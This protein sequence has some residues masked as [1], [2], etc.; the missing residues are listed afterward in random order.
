MP[1]NTI[2][3]QLHLSCRRTASITNLW[4]YISTAVSLIFIPFVSV[5]FQFFVFYLSWTRLNKT[6][7]MKRSSQFLLSISALRKPFSSCIISSKVAHAS[8][9]STGN[10]Y[11]LCFIFLL[12][13]FQTPSIR[14]TEVQKVAGV[15]LLTTH[16]QKTIYNT[17][18]SF[19][20]TE[21]FLFARPMTIDV[22]HVPN[23]RHMWLFQTPTTWCHL[24]AGHI[25]SLLL[26]F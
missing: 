6:N 25:C 14:P 7:F 15:A 13:P 4:G 17:P 3:V 26:W 5:A 21:P 20:T 11:T 12:H 18:N 8:W 10:T 24:C 16:Q 9:L 2:P 1:L 22:L 23:I 19:S